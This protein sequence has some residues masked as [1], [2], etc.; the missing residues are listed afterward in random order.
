MRP[1][2]VT[3]AAAAFASLLVG[4]VALAE[5]CARTPEK[6]A[7][8]VAGLKSELMVVAI[9]CQ[10]EDRY[11]SFISRFRSDLLTQERAVNGYF[12]R[13]AGRRATQQHDDYVTSL[14]NAQSQ[15]G[16]KRGTLF[17]AEHLSMF[18]AVMALPDGKDLRSY[19]A[20]Q[21]LAQ[22][23]DLTECPPPPAKKPKAAAH[24]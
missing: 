3:C 16:L 20:G 8:D 4:A 17:C 19:A 14:A 24:K 21:T 18:D 1:L 11:N 10:A 9:S 22:P 5:P 13:T 12:A 2:S 6:A 23:M 15:D 7:F